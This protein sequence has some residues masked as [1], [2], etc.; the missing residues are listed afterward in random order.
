MQKKKNKKTMKLKLTLKTT[1][2]PELSKSLAKWL[3][4]SSCNKYY[5]ITIPGFVL[6]FLI[7]FKQLKENIEQFFTK[8]MDEGKA[9]VRLKEPPVDICLSKVWY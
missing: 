3:S 9:T 5:W 2:H 8:F 6:F 4:H 1:K 7:G